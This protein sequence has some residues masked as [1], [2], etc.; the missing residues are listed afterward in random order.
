MY[1]GRRCCARVYVLV[2][3]CVCVCVCVCVC[4]RVC[5]T[6]Q[7]RSC[8]RFICVDAEDFFVVVAAV[9]LLLLFLLLLL[10]CW[11]W[12]WWWWGWWLLL[13]LLRLQALES[14]NGQLVSRNA[15]LQA[16][17]SAMEETRGSRLTAE[18]YENQLTEVK[19]QL[20]QKHNMIGIPTSRSSPLP[21][22]LWPHVEMRSPIFSI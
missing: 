11:W 13:L 10:W 5:Q 14:F 16:T 4:A 1:C 8:V 19:L 3:L 2:C 12:W 7:Q 21:Y 17:C 15:E 6:T 22:P 9:L 20:E 18:A